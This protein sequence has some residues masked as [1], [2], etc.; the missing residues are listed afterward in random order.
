MTALGTDCSID[1][2][3]PTFQLWAVALLIQAVPPASPS[4]MPALEMRSGAN[5]QQALSSPFLPFQSSSRKRVMFSQLLS[6]HL[7]AT[8]LFQDCGHPS[9]SAFP[10]SSVQGVPF[11]MEQGTQQGSHYCVWIWCH[12][13]SSV[14]VK[15]DNS[16]SAGC[17]P[18]MTWAWPNGRFTPDFESGAD[19]DKWECSSRRHST[20]LLLLR[21]QLSSLG[22]LPFRIAVVSRFLLWSRFDLFLVL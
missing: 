10:D 20:Q 17:W 1:A 19:R 2:H 11:W 6:S 9:Q 13:F 12:A 5:L 3:R 21:R 8:G 7:R 15:V 14:K 18:G 4:T 16:P 22:F